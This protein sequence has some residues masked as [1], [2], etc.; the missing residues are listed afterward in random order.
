V[1]VGSIA[2]GPIER[3]LL[4]FDAV[5][6]PL[7]ETI[8]PLV[9][10]RALMAATRRGVFDALAR[11]SATTNALAQRCGMDRAAAVPLLEALEASG[12]VTQ[13]RRGRWKN[14]SAA[15]RWL[16]P[17]GS[18][19][20]RDYLLFCYHEWAVL[21][22]LDDFLRTGRALAIHKR[23]RPAN[24][25]WAAYVRGMR[26]LASLAAD[27]IAR[28]IPLGPDAR[29]LLDVGGAHGEYARAVCRRY[30]RL[31]AEVLDL[32]PAVRV[33]RRLA[34]GNGTSD[35]LRFR[36][37][38]A[39]RV[40]LPKNRYDVCLVVNLLHHL[41]AR[42]GR[43]LVTR[44]AAAVAPGGMIAIVDA[45]RPPNGQAMSQMQGLLNLHFR[46]TSAAPLP[47]EVDVAGWLREGGL[48]PRASIKLRR[49]PGAN[50]LL[51]KRVVSRQVV[52]ILDAHRP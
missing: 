2:E 11:R 44:L 43:R 31:G 22:H 14:A 19:S 27:E 20:L 29:Q 51:A 7:V 47:L 48:V 3:L 25:F 24:G 42:D 23:A 8:L 9:L 16:A 17:R 30:P 50:L 37:G 5:P 13:D 46:L 38:D 52:E 35:R 26:A 1:K 18:G 21:E 10:A 12:Y 41:A 32:A 34:R 49:A 45:F 6:R 36:A 15:A 4:A 33:G 39:L 28:R 40:R